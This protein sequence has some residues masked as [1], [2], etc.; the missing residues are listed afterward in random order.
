MD[1]V[2]FFLLIRLISSGALQFS[3]GVATVFNI[4][5]GRIIIMHV[6][7]PIGAQYTCFV[8]NTTRLCLQYLQSTPQIPFRYRQHLHTHYSLTTNNTYTYSY[9]THNN[10]TECYLSFAVILYSIPGREE[11]KIKRSKEIIFS[12]KQTS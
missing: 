10:G 9:H 6:C 2:L 5:K 4:C 12:K 3:C 1:K 11:S 8:H 7:P